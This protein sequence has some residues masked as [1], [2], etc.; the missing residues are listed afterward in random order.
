[1]ICVV[2]AFALGLAACSGPSHPSAADRAICKS[3]RQILD[4][5][6]PGSAI[7]GYYL[8]ESRSMVVGSPP[9]P[10]TTV[11]FVRVK[12]VR[13]LVRSHDPTFQQV[14]ETQHADGD[15]SDLIQQLNARCSALRL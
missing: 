14:G 15:A 13:E 10:Q 2:V 3:V 11:T 9:G 5:L 1:V 4:H 12:F 7:P 8:S 6:P